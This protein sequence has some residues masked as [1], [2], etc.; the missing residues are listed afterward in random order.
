MSEQ[1]SWSAAQNLDTVKQSTRVYCDRLDMVTQT[2]Y[3]QI[4]YAAVFVLSY[5]ETE[6]RIFLLY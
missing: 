4:Q 3:Q 1:A 5:A 2:G 6:E